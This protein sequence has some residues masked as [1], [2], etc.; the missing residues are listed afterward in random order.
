[1]SNPSFFDGI[2]HPSR[3]IIETEG[4]ELKD[5]NLALCITGSV[6]AVKCPELARKLMR[7][8][9]EVKT[10][11]SEMATNL[12]TPDLMHWATGNPVVTELTGAIEHVELAQWADTILVAPATA[13]TIGKIANG[14]DDTPPTSLISVAQGLEKPI[15]IVPAMHKSMYTH[16]II[17][18]NISRLKE[19][20]MRFIEPKMEE[21]KAKIPPV[22]EIVE[23]ILNVSYPQDLEGKKVLVTAGPTFERV[24][25]VRILTNQS[26]G[27]MGICIARAAAVRGAE[28]TLIYGPGT[29]PEPF[30]I[31]TIR[32]ETTEE[33]LEAVEEKLE[34]KFD[35][36][37]A[38]AAP[39]DFE[40]KSPS[41]EKF[42]RSESVTLELL[43]TP[44]ILDK[45][46]EITEEMFLV[47]F[48]A[49][50]D[51]TDEQLM[52]A[53]E[54]K[55]K[56]HD[57]DLVVANDVMRSG[58]GF[59]A[60]TNEVILITPSGLDHVKSTKPHIANSIL[61]IFAEEL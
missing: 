3:D 54:E 48:K 35:L 24:D 11:M 34:D 2:M 53:G 49:E 4:G 40:P 55:M 57:L 10:I 22:E 16:E 45:V 60:D 21:G 39:Q 36:F 31:E 14:I 43:P 52:K 13:N 42:R 15:V 32:V 27:K 30:G 9:C 7:Q 59:G 26:S 37:V 8:G 5:Q 56:E 58:A 29:E 23:Y 51:V 17:E 25:P 61:D 18:D 41:D 46:S 12:I 50:C 1:M 33:M 19:V 44:G 38:A 6:A 20:G 28:V 47:G